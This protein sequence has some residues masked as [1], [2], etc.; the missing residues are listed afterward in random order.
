MSGVAGY[1]TFDQVDSDVEI[2]LGGEYSDFE[3]LASG[4]LDTNSGVKRVSNGVAM[5]G[6]FQGCSV[7]CSNGS[8]HRNLCL[9]DR[10]VKVQ[11]YISGSW[12]TV[13]EVAFIAATSTGFRANVI[14]ANSNI[15]VRI[16]ARP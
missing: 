5:D 11:E 15:P 4:Q 3:F 9:D 6:G 8:N 10:I 14:T 1:I 2:T 12:A 7:E 13:L 16:V